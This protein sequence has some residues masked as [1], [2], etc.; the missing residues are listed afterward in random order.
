MPSDLR[1][2]HEAEPT[3]E[4]FLDATRIFVGEEKFMIGLRLFAGLIEPEQA[5]LAYSALAAAMIRGCLAQVSQRFAGEHGLPPGGRCVVLGLGKLG[6]CEM[7][8]TSDLDLVLLYDFDA[9]QPEF[10]RGEA[11]PCRGL[12]YPPDAKA[13][14]GSDGADAARQAL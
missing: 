12:L 14:R 2:L 13:D 5:A 11:A 4:G 1:C 8:A 10:G 7:T 3:L 9:A 6:S